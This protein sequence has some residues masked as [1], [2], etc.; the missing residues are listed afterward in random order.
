MIGCAEQGI[1]RSAFPYGQAAVYAGRWQQYRKKSIK[2][3]E[4]LESLY[5]KNFPIGPGPIEN[6]RLELILKRELINWKIIT[7][8]LPENPFITRSELYREYKFNDFNSVIDY[9]G[10]VAIGCNVYPHHPRWEN[11]WTT[12]KVWLTT[13]DIEHIISYKDIMLARYMDITF[14]EYQPQKENLHSKERIEK[15]K[16]EFNQ[17]I[18]KLIAN[19]NLEQAFDKLNEFATLNR[20]SEII[21]ELTLIMAK[22]NRVRKSERIGEI[23]RGDAD[24]EYNKIRKSILELINE[25]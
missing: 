2:M 24:T 21:N 10:K 13:W 3:S 17:K 12:L 25:S 19:D 16:K 7:S 22:L 14:K 15:E 18:R 8:K 20:D 1:K 6:E 11:T 4:K 5:P 23:S 9:M